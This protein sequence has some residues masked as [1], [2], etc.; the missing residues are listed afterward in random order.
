VRT[1]VT[2][3]GW[4]WALIIPFLF[5]L[6]FIISYAISTLLKRFHKF[7]DSDDIK[8]I[9]S[10]WWKSY[11]RLHSEHSKLISCRLYFL[12]IDKVKCLK[13]GSAKK[14]LQEV[15]LEDGEYCVMN[16]ASDTLSVIRMDAD[17]SKLG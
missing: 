15:I 9:L 17:L 10:E 8:N 14:Y 2:L 1:T 13:K 11:K 16:E 5:L 12:S 4:Q 6:G 3:Y 7:R